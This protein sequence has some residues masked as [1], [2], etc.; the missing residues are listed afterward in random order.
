MHEVSTV[1]LYVLRATYLLLVVGI[2]LGLDIW[3]LLLSATPGVEH[4]RGVVWSLLAAVSLLAIVGLR[5]PLRMLPLLFFEL[6]WKS[7]WLLAIGVPL[8]SGNQLSPATRDTWYAC[9]VGVVIVSLA[10]P[11]GYVL[12][13][14]VKQPG[15]RWRT[16]SLAVA[17]SRKSAAAAPPRG[18]S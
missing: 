6:M 11:W 12:A 8:W 7:I 2:G 4:M 5:Y 18:S 17:Q 16:A 9:L 15:D 13:Q 10:I 3:S 1:R 14:Y